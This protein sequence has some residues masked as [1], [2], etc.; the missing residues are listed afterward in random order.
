MA[1][2]VKTRGISWEEMCKVS[3][4]DICKGDCKVGDVVNECFVF[5]GR[6]PWSDYCKEGD[7]TLFV[8]LKFIDIAETNFDL[9]P[10]NFI[11]TGEV[12]EESRWVRK[13]YVQ[14]L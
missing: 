9:S 4:M 13:E 7:Y 6:D 2:I 3:H 10:Y 14:G 12:N 1:R 5:L 11:K 8:P